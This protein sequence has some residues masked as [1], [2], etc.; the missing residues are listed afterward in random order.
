M[1]GLMMTIKGLPTTYN[2]DLQES[3][4]GFGIPFVHVPNGKELRPQ[5]EARMLELLEGQ[6][7]LVVLARYMQI[8]SADF[9]RRTSSIPCCP[10]MSSIIR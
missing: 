6:T 7:D 8:V 2:K 9:V 1:A 5:A 3:V 4:E 10:A